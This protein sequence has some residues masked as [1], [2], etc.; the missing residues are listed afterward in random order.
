M[1]ELPTPSRSDALQAA[2]E[3]LIR[4]GDPDL[5]DEDID[6]WNAWME[7]SPLHAR[8]F[9]DIHLLW[10]AAGEVGSEDVLAERSRTAAT[11]DM[12]SLQDLEEVGT[13]ASST[14]A[15]D[16]AGSGV[17]N[18][19][20][21]PRSTTRQ[22]RVNRRRS[23]V[24]RWGLM[25]ASVAA[26]AVLA[27]GW[28]MRERATPSTAP[29]LHFAA[30]IGMPRHVELPDGSVLELDAASEVV[31]QYGAQRRQLELL[32]GQ[33]YFSVEKDPSRPFEVRAGGV[34]AQALGT[35]FSVA[36]RNDGVRVVVV[37]GHVQ[38]S[39]LRANVEGVANKVVQL[40]AE[41]EAA[42]VNGF[43][44]EGPR[45]IDAASAIAWQKGNVIYRGEPL[46]N[47][48]A[49]LNRYSQVPILLEDRHLAGLPVTGRWSTTNV[50]LWLESIAQV[51]S[52]SVV[53]TQGQILLV[54]SRQ[55]AAA[56]HA[57]RPPGMA[58]RTDAA[59]A[60]SRR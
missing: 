16:S 58:L 40:V 6:A 44:M 54:P 48:V 9:E 15:A 5:R 2:A 45:S 8:A 41:Q 43:G 23:L 3:W 53:R 1:T 31:V 57:A 24:R 13:T 46:G 26:L 21:R 33:A 55:S 59:Y 47:V 32:R 34:M 11:T 56:L 36:R 50:D 17:S 14:L 49:D 4:L 38:V 39:D 20:F 37:E 60:Q 22:P 42:I 7:A 35:R 10:H 12:H 18:A 19:T 30:D 27:I 52:L 28:E 25:A 29:E 51:L